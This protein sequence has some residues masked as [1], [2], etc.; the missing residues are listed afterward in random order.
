MITSTGDLP[1]VPIGAKQWV[2]SSA[3]LS[4]FEPCTIYDQPDWAV[5]DSAS[6]SFIKNKPSIPTVLSRVFSTPTFSGATTATQ[7]STSRD[8]EVSYSFDATVTISLIAG[9]SVT[10][11]LSYADNSA[12]TT[13]SVVVDSIQTANSGVLSLTQINTLKLTGQIP[14]GKYRKV[15]FAVTGTGAAAPT[16]LKAGQ[17]VLL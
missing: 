11:T 13:N 8:A 2:R 15:T 9:Q 12:M 5:T 4:V 1:T 10:A 14:A 7:L 3:D 16:T 17:E 6:L